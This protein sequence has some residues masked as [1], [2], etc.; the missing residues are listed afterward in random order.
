MSN[1]CENQEKFSDAYYNAVKDAIKTQKKINKEEYE[2][3]K[4]TYMGMCALYFFFSVYAVM[5]AMNTKCENRVLNIVI[6][7]LFGPLYVLSQCMAQW[8]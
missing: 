3:H 4:G 2:K 6:A 1:V 7:F 8:S 5:L